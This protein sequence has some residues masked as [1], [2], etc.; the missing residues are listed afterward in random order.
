M[1]MER[2]LLSGPL[3]DDRQVENKDGQSDGFENEPVPIQPI[4]GCCL[5]A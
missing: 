2:R 4:A 1:V 5:G 3:S